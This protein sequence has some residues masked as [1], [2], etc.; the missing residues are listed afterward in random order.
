MVYTLILGISLEYDL[1][2]YH[3]H[4]VKHDGGRGLGGE[5]YESWSFP[6]DKVYG[7]AMS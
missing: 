4:L 6:Y 2:M 7:F 5:G 3:L 1:D